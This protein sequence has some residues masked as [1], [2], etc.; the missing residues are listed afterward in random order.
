MVYTEIL[1][2][3]LLL[4]TPLGDGS[5]S[6]MRFDSESKRLYWVVEEKLH[7][8]SLDGKDKKDVSLRYE[9]RLEYFDGIILRSDE[10]LRKYIYKY[11]ALFM[12][13]LFTTP[14]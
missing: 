8:I 4:T 5:V 7:S 9:R 11:L 1:K 13:S 14:W 10:K 12:L 6:D 3:F 2:F